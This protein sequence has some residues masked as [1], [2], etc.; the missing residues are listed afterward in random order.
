MEGRYMNEGNSEERRAKR[1]SAK[2]EKVRKERESAGTDKRGRE[3]NPE[4]P[5]ACFFAA[6]THVNGFHLCSNGHVSPESCRDPEPGHVIT[7]Q[8]I[9]SSRF[10]DSRGSNEKDNGG[11]I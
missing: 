11:T 3:A 5:M 4:H 7:V 9:A 1:E 10:G 8:R 6:R 2:R